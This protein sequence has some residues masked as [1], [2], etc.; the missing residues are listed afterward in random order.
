MRF[1]L[2]VPCFGR[3]GDF[4]QLAIEAEDAGW[5]GFFIWDHIVWKRE[6]V[7]PIVDP[8]VTLAAVATRT[9][10][11]V[12]GPLVT[13]LSRRRPMKV[14]REAATLDVLAGGR[15]ILGVGLGNPP[16]ADF[17]LFG[18]AVDV[19]TRAARLDEALDIVTGLWSGEPFSY[20]GQ[21]LKVASEVTFAPLPVQRPRVP[22]WV[23]GYWPRKAPLER[24]ARWDGAVPLRPRPDFTLT[25]E[26][27]RSLAAFVAERRDPAAAFDVVL[28]AKSASGDPGRVAER[29]A[30]YAGAGATWWVESTDFSPG[31]F[32]AMRR[33]VAA[34]PPA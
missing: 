33:R 22:V 9:Q 34:G 25:I 30:S 8:W 2:S 11:L 28:L 14:A 29:A 1:G 27:V 12:L 32:E 10:K 13:P 19:R 23:A 17:E 21:H 4:V 3:P 5:D 20:A 6:P 26:E 31:W 24:A 16:D 7:I 15:T 18:D